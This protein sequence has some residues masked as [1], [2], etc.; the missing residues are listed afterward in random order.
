MPAGLP[1]SSPGNIARAAAPPG[2]PAD[3]GEGPPSEGNDPAR[4]TGPWALQLVEHP[5]GTAVLVALAVLEACVFP[6]PTE[7]AFVALGFAHPRRSWRLAAAV[8]AGSL[9]GAAVGYAVGA[10]YFERV[11]RPLLEAVGLLDEFLT[12]GDLYRGNAVLALVTSGYTPIPYVL[13]APKRL[14]APWQRE[15]D[16]ARPAQVVGQH[17]RCHIVVSHCPRFRPISS[18]LVVISLD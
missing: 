16:T 7:A 3:T 18:L 1:S 6:A 5:A 15:T 14:V 12:V 9:V 4:Q 13:Q 10:A 11:G 2:A 8:T 17:R